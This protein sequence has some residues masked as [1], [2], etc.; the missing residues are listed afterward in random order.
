[1]PHRADDAE[2]RQP[3][4]ERFG[5]NLGVQDGGERGQIEPGRSRQRRT[6]GSAQARSSRARSKAA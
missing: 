1:M 3:V 5:A 6:A 2:V 4:V